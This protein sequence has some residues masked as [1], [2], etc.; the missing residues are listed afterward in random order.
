MNNAM[1]TNS[2]EITT[3]SNGD[4]VMWAEPSGSLHLKCITKHGDPVELSAEEVK[5]LCVMLERLLKSIE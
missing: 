1:N 5:E 3:L 2:D 4:I